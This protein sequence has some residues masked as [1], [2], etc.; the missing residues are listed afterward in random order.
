M[1][2]AEKQRAMRLS[3]SACNNPLHGSSRRSKKSLPA[4]TPISTSRYAFRRP[5][6]RKKTFS[7]PSRVS[8]KVRRAL[9]SPLFPSLA[10]SA[11]ERPDQS[12]VVRLS[13]ANPAFGKVRALSAVAAPQR[14]AL[15]FLSALVAVRHNPQM[16]SFYERLVG[17]GK[18]K[19][20]ALIAVARKLAVLLNAIL[21]DKRPWRSSSKRGLNHAEASI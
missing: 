13:P 8:V 3:K 21:P 12:S 4:S 9:C 5:G 17:A 20:V 18:A 2:V 19:M 10:R 14:A 7:S 1:I 15:F 16:K 6:A 11:P